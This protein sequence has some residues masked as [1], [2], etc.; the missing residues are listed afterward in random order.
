MM[1]PMLVAEFR[2]RVIHDYSNRCLICGRGPLLGGTYGLSLRCLNCGGYQAVSEPFGQGLHWIRAKCAA[3]LGS[4][5]AAAER[6]KEKLFPPFGPLDL[7]G[8]LEG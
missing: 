2:P 4:L 5:R 1:N 3:L 8:W 7:T 6:I